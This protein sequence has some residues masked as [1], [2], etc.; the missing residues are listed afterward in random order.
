MKT[1]KRLIS[2][3]SPAYNEEK[4]IIPMVEEVARV[5]QSLSKKYDYEYILVDDGSGDATWEK[6]LGEVAKNKK[7]KGLSLSR[8]F[9]QQLA[10]TAG[11]DL[12]KGD[13][14]IYLDS[15]LQQPPSLFPKLIEKWEGG[16]KV[17]HTLRTGSEDKRITKRFFSGLF[18]FIANI[19]SDTP[20]KQGMADFKLLDKEVYTL[21]GKMRE[22][23]R[24]LRGMVPWMGFKSETI[25]YKAGKRNAGIPWYNFQRN[26]N[27]AKTGI[28]SLSTKP[29]IL[30]GYLGII[31]TIISFLAMAVSLAVI[32]MKADIRYISPV[33]ILV[34]FNTFLFGIVL[35][36]L[37]IVALYISN[38]H[39]EI[40]KRPLYLVAK[41]ANVKK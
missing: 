9:G 5:M 1:K 20:I 12:A 16:V 22:R 6:I 39:Q 26:I 29:L 35:S 15:D 21:I 8:N 2:I 36:C 25:K 41:K 11:L 30:I 37:G 40:I 3:V 19:L 17:V 27:F 13:A 33:L 32:I 4:N 10:I 23:N 14:V 24:F 28:L 7:I 31:L 34:M 38:L 18:Y